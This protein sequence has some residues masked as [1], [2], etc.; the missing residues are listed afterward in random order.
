MLTNLVPPSVRFGGSSCNHWS[1]MAAVRPGHKQEAAAKRSDLLMKLL[2][3]P[4]AD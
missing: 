1:Q 4:S 2:A 3:R